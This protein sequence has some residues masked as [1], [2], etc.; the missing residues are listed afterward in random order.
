M[1]EQRFLTRTHF[2]RR[3]MYD[4][5]IHHIPSLSHLHTIS[6]ESIAPH[7]F[8]IL[9]PSLDEYDIFWAELR[10]S[11]DG[12]LLFLLINGDEEELFSRVIIDPMTQTFWI[13]ENGPM[14]HADWVC[15][16]AVVREKKVVVDREGTESICE[17]V[18][19]GD[20]K[21]YFRRRDM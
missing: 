4:V 8:T 9:H 21:V 14:E 17:G 20:M 3:Y 6:Y 5:Q 12:T 10:P 13:V 16:Y 7:I 2:I 15:C 19:G 11:D 18:A 1:V